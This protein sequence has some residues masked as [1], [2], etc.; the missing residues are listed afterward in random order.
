MNMEQIKK[1]DQFIDALHKT[2]P[3]YSA[4]EIFTWL[5]YAMAN[6]SAAIGDPFSK[7]AQ[8]WREEGYEYVKKLGVEA[9]QKLAQMVGNTLENDREQDFLGTVYQRLEMN[10]KDSKGQV[11]T[12]Y[13]IGHFMAHI[14]YDES[15]P[16][17]DKKWTV[18]TDPCCGAGALLLAH[19]NVAKAKGR[20]PEEEFF[21]VANDIDR[22]CCAMTTVQLS[23]LGMAGVVTCSD[24]LLNPITGG[25][26]FF[27]KT[28]H[29]DDIYYLSG[30]SYPVWQMRM[31]ESIIKAKVRLAEEEILSEADKETREPA[32]A[33]PTAEDEDTF[34][35]VSVGE[36]VQMTIFDLPVKEAAG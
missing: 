35:V 21:Y 26:I 28:E 33:E 25:N 10:S 16:H 2:D 34:E 12:P 27:P 23:M 14:T 9:F 22:F 4:R 11:F 19:S 15:K 7:R 1:V 13:H 30:C 3:K 18:V 6:L 29:E 20:T 31:I 36:C 8:R 32:E 5:V 24:A 17:D